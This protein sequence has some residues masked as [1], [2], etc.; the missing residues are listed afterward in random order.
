MTVSGESLV[1]RCYNTAWLTQ[2]PER[3]GHLYFP[4]SAAALSVH[5][6]ISISLFHHPYNWLTPENARAFR[7]HIE[8]SSDVV[9]TG[10]EHVS[11]TYVK[12]HPAGA[13]PVTFVE[14]AALFE[15]STGESGFNVVSIDTATEKYAVTEYAWAGGLYKPKNTT[16][17]FD[18][19]RRPKS[20]SLLTFTDQF[21]EYLDDLG[22]GFTH[23]RKDH[24]KLSDVFVCPDLRKAPLQQRIEGRRG[25]G[26][27][28]AGKDCPGSLMSAKR[29]IVMGA[30]KAG[31]TT[32]S[33]TLVK[34]IASSS[35][36]VPLLLT[37]NDIASPD[38]TTISRAVDLAVERQFGK[39]SIEPFRQL[40]S[41][42]VAL[43][44][45][46]FDRARLTRKGQARLLAWAEQMAASIIL[47][48]AD[49][50]PVDELT[51]KS[52]EHPFYAYEQFELQPLGRALKR[53]HH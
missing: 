49:T 35:D 44:L 6:G 15:S 9:L 26:A 19:V 17:T 23:P 20:S 13:G 25:T 47:T 7:I 27:R 40:P 51:T 11:D 5:D 41:E 53:G 38:A 8:G 46:D 10:H 39:Q 37:G 50:F 43:V 30:P 34:H 2:N 29:A 22:T 16:L 3:P 12:N 14:G 24:L 21:R 31:K 33:K 52:T 48:V 18:F 1:L 32:L 45:D 4:L 42:R 28:I 36:V